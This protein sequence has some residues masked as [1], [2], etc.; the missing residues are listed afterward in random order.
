MSFGDNINLLIINY[1]VTYFMT[2]TF[3]AQTFAYKH[4]PP[5][6]TEMNL[7]ASL[8][9]F[10]RKPNRKRVCSSLNRT[11]QNHYGSEPNWTKPNRD[12]SKSRL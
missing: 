4:V 8:V 2:V 1:Y 3:F 6:W 11:S 12:R 10:G 9:H 7:F 5:Y